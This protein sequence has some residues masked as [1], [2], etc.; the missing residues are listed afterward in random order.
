M[1]SLLREAAASVD[2]GWLLGGVTVLFLGI[3]IA[4]TW[5]AFAPK[6]RGKW[7]EAAKMPFMDGGDS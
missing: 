4:W 7:D 2:F 1:N 5:I 3:F 6:N